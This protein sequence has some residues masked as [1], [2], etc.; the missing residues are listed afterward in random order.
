MMI[1]RKSSSHKNEELNCATDDLFVLFCYL[2]R[3]NNCCNCEDE[4]SSRILLKAKH[5]NLNFAVA[6]SKFNTKNAL[7]FKHNSRPCVEFVCF[8]FF[9]SK[10]D[11]HKFKKNVG[12]GR[13]LQHKL[14]VFHAFAEFATA[15][16]RISGI[17]SGDDQTCCDCL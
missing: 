16:N 15:E 5:T 1:F 10:H 17:A 13:F 7:L 8:R 9:C 11:E 2:L 14:L 12:Q 4:H 6:Q 3:L